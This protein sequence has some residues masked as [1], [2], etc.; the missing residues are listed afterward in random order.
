MT[1]ALKLLHQ[2]G[3]SG[4]ACQ[5]ATFI[6]RKEAGKST[7]VSLTA[8]LLTEAMSQG[9][10][11]LNL[12]NPPE[13][14]HQLNT[15][16]PNNAADW[17]QQLR[18]AKSV[19]KPGDYTPLI[20]T[21]NG[22][23]YLYRFWRDEQDVAHAIMQ[24]RHAVDNV[25][26]EQ[27]QQDL[28]N[29]HNPIAGVDWQKVAVAMA[30]SRH[31][32]VISGG[33]GTGKT[34]IVL[35]ILQCLQNQSDSLRIG[36]AAPTGKAAARLQQSISQQQTAE[37]KTL[38]RLLGITEHNDQ[39]R[40]NAERP[41]PLDVLI[42]DEASM[43]DISLMAKLM[44]AMP[45]KAR[46]IL[47]GDSQQL[48]SVES[49]AVL[50]NL[51]ESQQGTFTADFVAQF[52]AL[53]LEENT[54]QNETAL[55]IDSFVRLQHSYR[56]DKDSLVGQLADRVNAADA[57]T[58][59]Q[60]LNEQTETIWFRTDERSLLNILTTGYNA[61]ISAVENRLPP[62]DIIQAFDQ[63]R[64]LAALKQGPQSVMSVNRLMSRF[65][66]QKGWRTNQ[67]FY[68]GRPIM[69]TQNDYRQQ[70]FNGDIGIILRDADGHLKACFYFGEVLRWVSLNRLPAHETV[71]AM[72]VHK[73]QGSEFDA[74][75]ILLP[76]EI[77]PILNRELLYTAITR[78]RKSLSIMATENALKHTI[79]SRHQRESGLKKQLKQMNT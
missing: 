66:A 13:I 3:F 49:G 79:N 18:E 7:V 10:V 32:A 1:E 63:F 47:L 39:G 54:H 16:L 57:E 68:S 12:A 31:L 59:I 76:D 64:V 35:K 48:A 33:P 52:P 62:Q 60:L 37:V 6:D 26:L 72:T 61:F 24:R 41:L 23:L 25:N 78:A 55:L 40:Y 69:I 38:H 14:I 21:E 70:L 9:H 19:G 51:S 28:A 73:S 75:S 22:L 43:I 77:S 36:L 44:R 46:L 30:L 65:L 56:F 71:F 11:C 42:I 58:T 17:Q 27:L 67:T 34:T 5:F 4:L 50:A 20:L 15:F 29:W 8:G 45:A 53:R 2:Q 74:V